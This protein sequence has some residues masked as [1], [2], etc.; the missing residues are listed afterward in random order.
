[1]ATVTLAAQL[2]HEERDLR[3]IQVAWGSFLESLSQLGYAVVHSSLFELGE[4]DVRLP[5][6]ALIKQILDEAPEPEPESEDELT[7]PFASNAARDLAYGEGL[8][9]E[10]F[11]GLKPSGKTGYTKADVEAVIG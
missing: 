6:P 7:V 11:A 8:A 9:D 2:S 5:D 3:P 1:M 10:D 4:H